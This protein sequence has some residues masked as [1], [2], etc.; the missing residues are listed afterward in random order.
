MILP[1][2]E[3]VLEDEIREVSERKS[4]EISILSKNDSI[5]NF[6]GNLNSIEVGEEVINLQSQILKTDQNEFRLDSLADE[7]GHEKEEGSSIKKII[8]LKADLENL[9]LEIKPSA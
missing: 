6:V 1:Y 2:K 7:I 3:F 4:Q 8:K 9:G 5:S